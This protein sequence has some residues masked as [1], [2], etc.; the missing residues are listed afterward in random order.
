MDSK[1]LEEIE[2]WLDEHSNPD[3]REHVALSEYVKDMRMLTSRLRDLMQPLPDNAEQV[4][5]E[6]R[7][8][9]NKFCQSGDINDALDRASS[10]V[11]RVQVLEAENATLRR[12]VRKLESAIRDITHDALA[13]KEAENE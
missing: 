8:C 7:W 9:N 1:R 6:A 3:K 11:R 5:K 4:I 13:P 10:A 2:M 12:H